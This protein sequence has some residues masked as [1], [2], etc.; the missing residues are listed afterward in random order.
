MELDVGRKRA[1]TGQ[2]LARR[3]YNSVDWPKIRR[4]EMSAWHRFDGVSFTS[5]LDERRARS[6]G[7]SVRSTV[8]PNAVDVEPFKPRRRDP[9][10][11]R[12]TVLLFVALNLLPHHH[13]G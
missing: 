4:E 10:P 13:R 2:G 12:R 6:L 3:L 9:S 7:P 8:I 5:A 1:K 11:D